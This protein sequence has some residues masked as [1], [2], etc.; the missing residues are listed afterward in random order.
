MSMGESI[1]T[2][3]SSTSTPV[4]V[5]PT[6]QC[7]E[8]VLE[9]KKKRLYWRNMTKADIAGLRGILP[10]HIKAARKM[11][12]M[13]VSAFAR[14]VGSYQQALS[15]VEQGKE[16]G[17]TREGGWKWHFVRAL[18]DQ[19][20]TYG[21]QTNN[22][23]LLDVLRS[24]GLQPKNDNVMTN[25][26]GPQYDFDLWEPWVARGDAVMTFGIRPTAKTLA[27]NYPHSDSA[28]S[29]RLITENMMPRFKPGDTLDVDP[30]VKPEIGSHCLF[31]SEDRMR[32]FVGELAGITD[33]EWHVIQISR[34]EEKTY[35][36]AILA[37]SRSDWPVCE[38]IISLR[39]QK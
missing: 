1:Y 32:R 33:D 20:W 38:K 15:R 16:R 39:F 13:S 14:S 27:P 25:S 19:L 17:G 12:G 24:L 34:V 4:C 7:M 23:K 21:T 22:A 11:T 2:N 36:E 10:E 37:Y 8:I 18:K 31:I 26:E 30:E 6:Q 28:Y 5:E 35:R 29:F 3:V 9:P